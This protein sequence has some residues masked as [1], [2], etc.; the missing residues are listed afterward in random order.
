MGKWQLSHVSPNMVGSRGP[1]DP[2]RVCLCYISEDVA[3]KGY[4]GFSIICRYYRL[5][6]AL[7]NSSRTRRMEHF[8]RLLLSLFVRLVLRIRS[9]QPYLSDPQLVVPGSLNQTFPL[10]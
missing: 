8:N 2:T 6:W 1:V 5:H 7:E 4:P 3:E 10:T 9:V